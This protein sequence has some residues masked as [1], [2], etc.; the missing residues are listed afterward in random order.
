MPLAAAQRR[1]PS[2]PA[3]ALACRPA[4]PMA[5]TAA[6]TPPALGAASG[7][8]AA[9]DVVAVDTSAGPEGA[10]VD[11]VAVDT[12]AGPAAPPSTPRKRKQPCSGSVSP[13]WQVLEA[14]GTE[15]TDASGQRQFEVRCRLHDCQCPVFWE[16]RR[17][18]SRC[19]AHMK[20]WH[21]LSPTELGA[22]LADGKAESLLRE[23][24]GGTPK[25]RARKSSAT[26]PLPQQTRSIC[27]RVP[28]GGEVQAKLTA[29]F[30]RNLGVM[31]GI[32]VAGP[33]PRGPAWQAFY[34]DYS[35]LTGAKLVWEGPASSSCR[36][37]LQLDAQAMW[38]KLREEW[39]QRSCEMEGVLCHDAWDDPWHRTIIGTM[40]CYLGP[41][42]AADRR[43]QTIPPPTP[44]CRVAVYCFVVLLHGSDRL[45]RIVEAPQERRGACSWASRRGSASPRTAT[46]RSLL[47]PAGMR[48]CPLMSAA[49]GQR[50]G[51]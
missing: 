43:A 38:S 26:E 24:R 6:P 48:C 51:I 25:K 21:R 32:P 49:C 18:L 35:N 27:L 11:L 16:Q 19:W 13:V 41:G 4:A 1:F 17:S 44:V 14:S 34:R 39:A 42:G 22:I 45:L 47:W 33:A 3:A 40:L 50:T 37:V 29:S 31:A 15:R 28:S 2:Y 9:Q 20:K 36:R 7:E 8:A 46:D 12:S 23:G 5:G 30:V 10:V